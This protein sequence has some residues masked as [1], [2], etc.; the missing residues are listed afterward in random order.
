MIT[1][2]LAS[3][4]HGGPFSSDELSLS[5]T[6][7]QDLSLYFS[8]SLPLA[9]VTM[10]FTHKANYEGKFDTQE[11]ELLVSGVYDLVSENN[12][13]EISI[14]D[15][16]FDVDLKKISAKHLKL[17]FQYQK[18]ITTSYKLGTAVLDVPELIITGDNYCRTS[19][20]CDQG[21]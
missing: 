10:D 11:G 12:K 17:D 5:D 13:G 19:N 18:A 20:T 14:N 21:R 6:Q 16:Q 8:E 7:S 2:V 3:G 4:F 9:T 15:F 1:W